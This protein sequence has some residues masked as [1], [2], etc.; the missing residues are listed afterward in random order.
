MMMLHGLQKKTTVTSNEER[1]R[2]PL[3]LAGQLVYRQ[4]L[5]TLTKIIKM[6]RHYTRGAFGFLFVVCAAISEEL[7]VSDGDISLPVDMTEVFLS[8]VEMDSS[9]S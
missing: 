3:R 1:M 9:R 2:S 4:K 5:S 8:V 6:L 7:G